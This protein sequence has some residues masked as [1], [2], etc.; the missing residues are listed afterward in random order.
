M[1][2]QSEV[3]ALMGAVASL[4]PPAFVVSTGDNFYEHGLQV[5]GG[6][7]GAV[8]AVLHCGWRSLF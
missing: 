3:A 1:Y 6:W 8:A 7:G 2:N 4:D 5:C